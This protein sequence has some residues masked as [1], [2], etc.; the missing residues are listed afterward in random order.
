MPHCPAQPTVKQLS[1]R[2]TS[3]RVPE[4][5]RQDELAFLQIFDG[6]ALISLLSLVDAASYP[7]ST[8][9]YRG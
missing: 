4:A 9:R 2:D 6:P 8:A 7:S 3:D 5:A 1:T